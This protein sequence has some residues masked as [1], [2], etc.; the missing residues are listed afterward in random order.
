MALAYSKLA[1]IN[2]YVFL[3]LLIVLKNRLQMSSDPQNKRSSCISRITLKLFKG[4]PLE[5]VLNKAPGHQMSKSKPGRSG[6]EGWGSAG[7][8]CFEQMYI[9]LIKSFSWDGLPKSFP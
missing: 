8:A 9:S 6:T 2:A 4:K 1:F 3:L 7:K 5:T